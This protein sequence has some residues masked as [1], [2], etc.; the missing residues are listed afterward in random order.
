M[1]FGFQKVRPVVLSTIV[2]MVVFSRSQS[3]SQSDVPISADTA[4]F[5]TWTH[6]DAPMGLYLPP[7]SDTPLPVLMFLH[8]CNND[9]VYEY[10]WIIS[11]LNAIEPCAV[12]LPT[13]LPTPNTEYSCAD[14]GGTYDSQLRP[15]M[16]GA[17]H[18]LDS[19]VQSYG[20]AAERQ[21]LYGESMGGEG[22]YRLLMDFPSRF[23]GAVAAAGYTLDKGAENMAQTPLW[24]FHGSADELSPVENDRAIFASIRDAGGTMVQYT[25]Y[26]GLGHVPGIEQARSEPGVLEWL[27]SQ[28]RSTGLQKPTRKSGSRNVVRLRY[29]GGTLFASSPLPRGTVI[30]LS[31]LGGRTLFTTTAD[32]SAIKLPSGTTNGVAVWRL[33]HPTFRVSGSIPICTR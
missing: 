16:T 22:V 6:N 10:F 31:D 19:L 20:F 11:A 8:G 4:E 27:L 12:F 26:E 14:W 7:P 13:A 2:L 5:I 3:S 30:S 23:A 33:A 1:S 28:R 29:S 9:P 21:Y 17:L 24:I 15:Q 18:E 25:E 32:G